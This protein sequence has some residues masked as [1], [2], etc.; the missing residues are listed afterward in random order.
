MLHASS[1]PTSHSGRSAAV[2]F[3]LVCALAVSSCGSGSDAAS[4][5]DTS[6]DTASDDTAA[7]DGATQ[8]APDAEAQPDG[9]SATIVLTLDDGTVYEMTDVTSCD[10]SDTDPSGFPLSNGYD[11]TG[12]TDAGDFA[13]TATRA[14][15]DDENSVFAGALEGDFDDEGKNGQM[16]YSLAGDGSD[17]TADGTAVSGTIEARA[18]AP[19]QPHGDSTMIT[20]DANC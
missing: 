13:F 20:V 2:V 19:N 7:D 18:I 1:R 8:D 6:D 4:D 11:L 12:R 16:L 5:T 10:T 17:L 3:G 14:G 9:G 15:I